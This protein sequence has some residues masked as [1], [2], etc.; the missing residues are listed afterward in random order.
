MHRQTGR[1]KGKAAKTRTGSFHFSQHLAGQAHLTAA[2]VAAVRE[3]GRSA[4][5]RCSSAIP[6]RLSPR[7][8]IA[9]ACQ[10]QQER[11]GSPHRNAFYVAFWS[12]NQLK[13]I[14][15]RPSKLRNKKSKRSEGNAH[16]ASSTNMARE[17]QAG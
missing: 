17:G 14:K 2:L 6:D 9:A 10:G 11:W 3:L 4:H 7:G 5:Q 16:T 15:L 12:H 13:K 1:Y 8:Q